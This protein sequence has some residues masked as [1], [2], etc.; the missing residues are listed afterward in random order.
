M[1]KTQLKPATFRH[2]ESEIY[3]YHETKRAIQKRREELLNP[4]DDDPEDI[5]IVKGP[6]SVREPGRPTERLATRLMM[7]RELRNAEEIVAAIQQTYELSPSERQMV[8]SIRYWSG[9]NPNWSEVAKLCNMHRH[10]V[11]KHRDEF[12]YL[13]AKKIGWR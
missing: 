8:I 9:G 3:A 6:N 1:S 11:R 13:V 12:V 5:N 2:V 7:D 4:F 10:T